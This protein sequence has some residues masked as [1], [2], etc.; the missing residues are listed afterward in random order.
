MYQE[1]CTYLG[2]P[3]STVDPARLISVQTK[4]KV[5]PEE[6]NL[7]CPVAMEGPEFSHIIRRYRVVSASGTSP[8]ALI[9]RWLLSSAIEL[10]RHLPMSC[11]SMTI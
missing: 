4:N 7:A 10:G 2:H 8:M 9:R 11:W 6:D 1:C 3:L 5:E